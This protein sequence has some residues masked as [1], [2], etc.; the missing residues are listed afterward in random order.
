MIGGKEGQEYIYIECSKAFATPDGWLNITTKSQFQLLNIT[1]SGLKE[2]TF[3]NKP[4]NWT[5][6]LNLEQYQINPGIYTLTASNGDLIGKTQ[7]TVLNN[8]DWVQASFPFVR[9]H[10]GIEYT[11]YG[12]GTLIARYENDKLV[13]DFDWLVDLAKISAT[14]KNIVQNDMNLKGTWYNQ[15][16]GYKC[17]IDFAKTHLGLKQIIYLELPE[18]TQFTFT[19]RKAKQIKKGLESSGGKIHFDYTDLI[20]FFSEYTTIEENTVIVSLPAGIHWIDPTINLPYLDSFE[21]APVNWT[22]GFGV[23]D[24]ENTDWSYEGVKSAFLDSAPASDFAYATLTNTQQTLSVQARVRVHTAPPSGGVSPVLGISGTGGLFD[25]PLRLLVYDNTTHLITRIDNRV[26]GIGFTD[27]KTVLSENVTY[28]FELFFDSVNN[29][30]IWWIDGVKQGSLAYGIGDIGNVVLGKNPAATGKVWVD[31]LKVELNYIGFLVPSA[32]DY[33]LLVNDASSGNP[34][35]GVAVTLDNGTLITGTTNAI[36]QVTFS[37]DPDNYT[38]TLDRTGYYPR[39][40][41]RNLDLSANLN[42]TEL[43]CELIENAENDDYLRSNNVTLAELTQNTTLGEITLDPQTFEQFFPVTSIQTVVGSVF[44]GSLASIQQKGGDWYGVNETVGTPAYTID[45]NITG[46]PDDP[47]NA[48]LKIREFYVGNPAHVVNWQIW[49]YTTSA[50]VTLDTFV[51]TVYLDWGWHNESIAAPNHVIQNEVMK[52]RIDHVSPGNV[53]HYQAIDFVTF[54]IQANG[55]SASGMI[56]SKNLALRFNTSG[57][58]RF[59][60]TVSYD[61]TSSARLQLSNDNSSWKSVDNSL[62]SWTD[63]VN[64]S[65]VFMIE[66]L[67]LGENFFYRIEVLPD[68][69][70]SHTPTILSAFV[71]FEGDSGLIGDI[72]WLT[73]LIWLGLMAVAMFKKTKV[74]I[75]FAGF[76]GLIL[77]LLLLPVNSMIAVALLLLNFYLIYE[78]TGL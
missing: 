38:T 14:T 47:M 35:S 52:L 25:N 16:T 31:Y 44:R 57:S 45:L 58:I 15:E 1:I 56:N 22:I 18:P 28:V 69:S 29:T 2:F 42:R 73:A 74:L 13:L 63:L 30:G 43:M 3:L 61:Q 9:N 41:I 4:G 65:N 11:T 20:D 51:S 67:D 26:T 6:N 50:W 72:N 70:R 71:L 19:V 17:I 23:P 39:N 64:G 33:I 12:N 8:K 27:G 75:M 53:N 66:N 32:F 59:E 37:L 7:F 36:G 55:Y 34:I 60:T 40:N 10:L 68:S 54:E 24:L 76:F 21:N 49:N 77:G 78:G 46:L 62:G 5:K 48:T